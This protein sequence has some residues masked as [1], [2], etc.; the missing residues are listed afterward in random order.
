MVIAFA[1]AGMGTAGM[2]FSGI[3]TCAKNFTKSRGMAL[4]LPIAS[5]GLSSLWQS[6]FI[7]RVFMDENGVLMVRAV[8]IT[9]AVYLAGVSILGSL[10]LQVFPE[11]AEPERERLLSGSGEDGYGYPNAVEEVDTSKHW[12]NAETHAYLRDK[13]MWLFAAG[14]FLVTGPG[15]AFMNNMGTLIHTLY[16]HGA[17]HPPISPATHVSII[18][19]TSTLARISAGILSDYLAPRGTS[20]M[21]LLLTAASLLLA[22]QVLLAAGFVDECYERF[23]LISALVGSGYGSVFTLAPTVVSVVWG[24]ENFGTNWGVVMVAPAGGATVCGLLYAVVY[25]GHADDDG[26]CWGWGC[27]RESFAGMAVGSVA[28]LIGWAL[29]WKIWRGRGVSV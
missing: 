3:T 7:S 8:F 24:T 1:F 21:T 13:T 20:R 9:Y 10:C 27:Y 2:Y 15:E 12:I 11:E 17:P 4:S 14:L 25:D 18:A 22:A 28:A 19:T 23:W 16:P 29:M 5:F 6:Q 26:R